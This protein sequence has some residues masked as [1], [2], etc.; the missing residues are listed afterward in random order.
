MILDLGLLA[1]PRTIFAS[2]TTAVHSALEVGSP[3][4]DEMKGQLLLYA[5]LLGLAATR[6]QSRPSADHLHRHVAGRESRDGQSSDGLA[7]QRE[8]ARAGPLGFGGAEVGAEVPEAR[9]REQR[10]AAGVG[11]DVAIGVT[12]QPGPLIG[13]VQP[14]HPHRAAGL[15]AMDVRADPDA[16]HGPSMPQRDRKACGCRRAG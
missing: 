7:Q 13:P 11:G 2:P 4:T 10:I 14:G 1:A 6:A 3:I 9:R 12:G 15:E 16:H 8:A 5:S